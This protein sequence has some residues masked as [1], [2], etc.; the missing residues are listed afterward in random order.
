M[1]NLAF[2][3]VIKGF[4]LSLSPCSEWD[5][6]WTDLRS[7]GLCQCP[8]VQWRAGGSGCGQQGITV[9]CPLIRYVVSVFATTMNTKQALN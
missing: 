1:N 3:F 6:L 9:L 5:G 2:I 4:T 7:G 8:T